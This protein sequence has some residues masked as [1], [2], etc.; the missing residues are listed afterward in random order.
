MVD[1]VQDLSKLQYELIKKLKTTHGRMVAVGDKKQAI[2]SFQGSNLDTLQ[3]IE[4]APNTVS[5]PLSITY[6]C[7]KNV[8]KEANKVFP[9]EIFAAD[10]AI[11]GEIIECGNFVNAESGD[12]ILC[13][14]NF[15]LVQ[16]FLQLIKCGK[17]C[18]ILGRDFGDELVSLIN[19][20][21]GIYEFEHMLVQLEEK[22]KE[23]GIRKPMNSEVYRS[24]NEKV[25]I[26]IDLY[27][28]FGDLETVK[29]RMYDI[30]TDESNG[31]VLSTIHKSKGLEAN[32]VYFLNKDLIP[33]KYAETELALYSEK[34]L[35]FVGITR[36]KNKLIYC[37]I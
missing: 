11:D 12:F 31:I 36:S 22:L 9:N 23:R 8:V 18:S 30:F 16:A 33:S 6:R 21:S 13:R 26:L 1:E 19:N 29:N 27:K 34:C 3:N 10:N 7:S 17:K 28:Y 35:K 37:N 15:P 20:V 25:N 32:N 4:C 5:L 2:Y 24:L 14:N